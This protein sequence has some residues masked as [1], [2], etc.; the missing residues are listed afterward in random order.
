MPK[1]VILY[2]SLTWCSP[3]HFSWGAI[4]GRVNANVESVFPYEDMRI[5]FTASSSIWQLKRRTFSISMNP[6]TPMGK[7]RILSKT[8]LDK[9]DS[10]LAL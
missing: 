1:S 3:A 4:S 9:I 10:F 8:D 6:M 2:D 5:V 7:Y